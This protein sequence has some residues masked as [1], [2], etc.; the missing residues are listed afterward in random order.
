MTQ[1]VTEPRKNLTHRQIF[2]FWMPLAAT[3]L[4]M[5]IEG[6]FLAAVIARLAEPKFNLAAYG[7][8]FSVGLLVEAPI[9]MIMSAAVALVNGPKSYRQLKR[10]TWILNGIISVVMIIVVL[11]PVFRW[12]AIDLLGL[13]E[14]VARL[15]HISTVILLPWPA[16]IGYRRFYQGVMI[17][18][19]RTRRVAYGT[20][21]RLVSMGTT[22]L[23]LYRFSSLAGAYIGTTALSVGVILEAISGRIMATD[24]VRN[25]KDP[26]RQSVPGD[27]VLG[28]R[29]ITRF[30]YPLA[31]SSILALGAYPMVNFFVSHGRFP[32]ESLAV[33][34]VINA[35][36]F[37]FGSMGLSFQEVGI[38]LMGKHFEHYRRIRNFAF[39][40]T[41]VLV[42]CTMA[43]AFT[44]L[45]TVWFHHVSGLSRELTR[46]SALPFQITILIP[47]FIALNSLQRSILV[48]ARSNSPISWATAIE[49]AVIIMVMMTAI[50]GLNTIGAIAAALAMTIG[51]GVAL[52][53]LIR[54]CVAVLNR[55]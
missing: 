5:A 49:V 45:M 16:A 4:M 1:H 40:L 32:I 53:Y 25:L 47:G 18:Y 15:A 19:N 50:S 29:E 31:I 8:S 28:Y 23:I 42:I 11:P 27:R 14:T 30:Y 46:F 38:A 33:L 55:R 10:Y 13:P 51:R 17:R 37:I 26:S 35:T 24:I 52:T 54:P 21:V 3:W 34:P 2:V 12:L 20:V 41:A 7:L 44:P 6:P 39:G 22:A 9:I 36:N 43:I 48:N